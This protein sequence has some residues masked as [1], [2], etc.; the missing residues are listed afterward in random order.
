MAEQSAYLIRLNWLRKLI[1]GKDGSSENDGH[2]QLCSDTKEEPSFYSE[3]S[4]RLRLLSILIAVQDTI[5]FFNEEISKAE[6]SIRL[7][8]DEDINYFR[9]CDP[10][11]IIG[12]DWM[13]SEE[14]IVQE[15]LKNAWKANLD[16]L[17]GINDAVNLAAYMPIKIKPEFDEKGGKQSLGN[18]L[19]LLA[20][21]YYNTSNLKMAIY[22]A[23]NMLTDTLKRLKSTILKDRGPE[24]YAQLVSAQWTAYNMV[25]DGEAVEICK[26]YEADKEGLSETISYEWLN[27]RRKKVIEEFKESGFVAAKMKEIGLDAHK[28]FNR[29]CSIKNGYVVFDKDA[30]VGKFICKQRICQQQMHELFAFRKKIDLIQEDLK[31][32][33][34]KDSTQKMTKAKTAYPKKRNTSVPYTIRYINAN[35]QSRTQRLLLLMRSLQYLKWIVEPKS[36]DYFYDLFDGTPCECNIKWTDTINQATIYYFLQQLLA[37]PYIE[38]VT[39]CSAR[40]LMMNQFHISNPRADEKRITID[41]K[42][43]ISRLLAIIDPQKQLPTKPEDLTDDVADMDSTYWNYLEDGLHATKDINSRT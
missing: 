18:S 14:E 11:W 2:G 28:A 38:K 5:H 20:G 10:N 35:E 8:I 15:Q 6:A 24:V 30:D 36:A 34:I 31:L 41:N 22:N 9:W 17:L 23:V 7:H 3:M 32:Y 43:I 12:H 21:P 42:R 37:Q 29:L 39:G 16:T 40:S 26:K 27:N 13:G 19:F 33:P 1:V 4:E 25:R